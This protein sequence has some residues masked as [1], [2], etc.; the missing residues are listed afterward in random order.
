MFSTLVSTIKEDLK[1]HGSD[2]TRPGFQALAVH[3][4]GDWKNGI[5]SK[6]LRAPFSLAAKTMFVFVRNFYGIEL[7]FSAR[8]GRRVIF[9]HQHGIVIHGNCV[10]GDD[11]II[12]QGVTMGIRRM[13]RLHEAPVIGNRV[14]IGAGAKLLGNIYVADDVQIGA[15]SVVL[16]NVYPGGLVV[17]ARTRYIGGAPKK[18]VD[19]LLTF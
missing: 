11:C 2:W 16:Q 9:E 17:C 19:D 15:N 8:I 6:L 10:I 12:R 4:F 18:V 3:R 1:A 14:N 7:P 13:D 5:K